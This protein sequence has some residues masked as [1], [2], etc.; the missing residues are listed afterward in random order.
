VEQLQDVV[1]QLRPETA[2]QLAASLANCL[3]VAA[4]KAWA[5]SGG[6]GGGGGGCEFKPAGVNGGWKCVNGGGISSAMEP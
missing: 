5:G 6:G 3:M 1:K 4:G 2:A